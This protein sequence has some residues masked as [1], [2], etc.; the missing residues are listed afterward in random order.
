M[1]PGSRARPLVAPDV[2]VLGA[3]GVAGEA[4]M[5]GVLAGIEDAAG[6]DLR[7]TE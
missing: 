5:A 6:L 4:W 1:P 3:G 7:R 2:L